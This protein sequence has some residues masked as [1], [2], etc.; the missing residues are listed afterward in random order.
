M[1]RLMDVLFV[2]DPVFAKSHLLFMLGV[3]FLFIL[4]VGLGANSFNISD[5]E[6]I[7]RKSYYGPCIIPQPF[8][9]LNKT[10]FG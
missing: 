2:L 7:K 8:K 3:L 6:I 10:L 1:A 9:F 4:S 5:M